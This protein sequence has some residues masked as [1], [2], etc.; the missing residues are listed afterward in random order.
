M[1]HLQNMSATPAPLDTDDGR[2]LSQNVTYL[3]SPKDCTPA[4]AIARRPAAPRILLADRIDRQF[5]LIR[6]A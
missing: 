6:S 2:D 5:P 3:A 1:D 4:G